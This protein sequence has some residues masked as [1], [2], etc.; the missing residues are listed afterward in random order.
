MG[1]LKQTDPAELLDPKTKEPYT[2]EALTFNTPILL[3]YDSAGGGKT[4]QAK[5][6]A[7]EWGAS[8]ANTVEMINYLRNSCRTKEEVGK[9][10]R[11]L[12]TMERLVLDDLAYEPPE[13][14]NAMGT[15]YEPR[16]ILQDILFLR[17]RPNARTIITT[18]ISLD[19]IA[20]IYDKSKT[21]G[22]KRG[23]LHSRIK[24]MATLY[25]YQGDQRQG[26]KVTISLQHTGGTQATIPINEAPE[27]N[28]DIPDK[29]L[30]R[31]EVQE[32][33]DAVKGKPGLDL[34]V[35][36]WVRGTKF[37]EMA[38]TPEEEKKIIDKR[39]KEEMKEKEEL[40]IKSEVKEPVVTR[41]KTKNWRKKK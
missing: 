16:R 17:A 4:L 33:L 26:E 36:R 22:A 18:N 30:T 13:K 19:N 5:K 41:E 37:A 23:R 28:Q 32:A 15:E 29:P 11:T 24:G 14:I 8:F 10:L 20:V 35:W 39:T 25:Y 3:L 34:T 40:G 9:Y 2:F 7:E 21:D 1:F 12:Q 38:P 27:E 31:E 6:I